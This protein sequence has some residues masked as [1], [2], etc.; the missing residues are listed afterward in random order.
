MGMDDDA[1]AA[2]RTRWA[3]HKAAGHALT[4]WQQTERGGWEKRAG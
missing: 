3:T 4:Y 2:A 1:V